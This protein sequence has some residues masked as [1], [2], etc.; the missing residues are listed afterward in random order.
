M[1][2]HVVAHEDDWQL[3]FNPNAY[4]DVTNSA[5]RV[6]FIYLTAGDAGNGTG[7]V[8]NP[9]FA[10]REEGAR[11]AVRFMADVTSSPGGGTSR[12]LRSMVM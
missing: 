10:A 1:T 8:G 5:V 7:P 11:R 2:F 3:F 12:L 4:G 9:Y 6:V